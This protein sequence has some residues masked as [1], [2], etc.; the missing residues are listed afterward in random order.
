VQRA[1]LVLGL[2]ACSETYVIGDDLPGPNVTVSIVP[3]V[4]EAEAPPYMAW[5]SVWLTRSGRTVEGNVDRSTGIPVIDTDNSIRWF[6]PRM[7]THGRW[8]DSNGSTSQWHSYENRIDLYWESRDWWISMGAA[9]FDLGAG[10]FVAGN[11]AGMGQPPEFWTQVTIAPPMAEVQNAFTAGWYSGAAFACPSLDVVGWLGG[12]RQIVPVDLF[13]VLRADPGGPRPIALDAQPVPRPALPIAGIRH[14]VC[15]GSSVYVGGG[16][17]EREDQPNTGFWR[18]DLT[19]GDRVGAVATEL[20][21]W[22]ADMNFPYV[23]YDPDLGHIVVIGDGI[24]V[25]DIATD[26]WTGDLAPDD[27]DARWPNLGRVMGFFEPTEGLFYFRGR[28][29][30]DFEVDYGA[31]YSTLDLVRTP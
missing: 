24:Y 31:R 22:P 17:L 15:V 27:W 16:H 7:R 28:Y 12:G 21:P 26:E 19:L 23:G 20:A 11:I 2:A 3:N 30:N 1:F 29:D 18:I 9:I 13:V 5:N 25:Y 6:D 4:A 14:A 8:F 10:A